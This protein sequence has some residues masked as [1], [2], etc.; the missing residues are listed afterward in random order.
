MLH[1]LDILVHQLQIASKHRKSKPSSAMHKPLAIL[2]TNMLHLQKNRETKCRQ[3][4][5]FICYRTNR[6]GR[7]E[8]NNKRMCVACTRRKTGALREPR[9]SCT[10]VKKQVNE[11]NDN[12]QGNSHF[13]NIFGSLYSFFLH[14]LNFMSKKYRHVQ[15]V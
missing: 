7:N 6:A 14:F 2:W 9:N 1:D 13:L 11:G 5:V 8:G 15:L 4:K 12:T 10:N 3:G